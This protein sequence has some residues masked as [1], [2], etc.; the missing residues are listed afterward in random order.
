MRVTSDIALGNSG[1]QLVCYGCIILDAHVICGGDEHV[2]RTL[3]ILLRTNYGFVNC[4]G[5]A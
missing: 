2:L 3:H 1:W 5:V 4:S